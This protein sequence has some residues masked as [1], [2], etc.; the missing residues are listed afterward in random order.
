MAQLVECLPG[1]QNIAGLNP[2]LGNSFCLLGRKKLSLGVVAL[3]CLVSLTEF[4][5]KCTYNV[6]YHTITHIITS[7]HCHPSPLTPHSTCHRAEQGPG[8]QSEDRGDL[9]DGC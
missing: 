6:Q 7:S 4:T 2:A 9:G 5:C 3:L 8:L 1:T